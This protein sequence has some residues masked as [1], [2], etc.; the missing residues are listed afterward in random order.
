M[1]RELAL[2]KR[3]TIHEVAALAGVSFSTAAAALRGNGRVSAQTVE[4]VKRAAGELGY[5]RSEAASALATRR[6]PAQQ[7]T[8][9]IAVVTTNQGFWM[10]QA[11]TG[12]LEREAER[13]G[14][15]F[16]HH[17]VGDA[18]TA[19][20]LG[21]QLEATGVEGLIRIQNQQPLA[22]MLLPWDRF[23]PV[24]IHRF[25]VKEGF[26]V[27]RAN[28]FFAMVDLLR[29]VQD[30]GYRRIGIWLQEHEEITSDEEARLGGA[31]LF[32]SQSSAFATIERTTFTENNDWHGSVER[33]GAWI[34][35][36]RLDCVVGFNNGDYHRWMATGF[37]DPAKVGYAHSQVLPE[38]N[39]DAAGSLSVLTMMAPVVLSRLLVKL[40]AGERGLSRHPTENVITPEFHPGP[41]L[42][43]RT[44]TG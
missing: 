19:K 8:F 27:V 22:P 42:P 33:M 15:I 36:H 6:R 5:R 43:R 25:H 17:R 32:Q 12:G 38:E 39:P 24:S 11:L 20:K 31:L 16:S 13:L 9:S 44:R 28:D 21:R 29:R 10:H 40:R 35:R 2:G 37:G 26:D 23:T 7:K 14:L 30:H 18:A 1:E 3:V 41:T 34:E 4:R